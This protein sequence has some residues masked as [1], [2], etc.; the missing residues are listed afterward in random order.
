LIAA[1]NA[2]AAFR[3][4]MEENSAIENAEVRIRKM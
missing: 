4:R 2:K 1:F 3:V